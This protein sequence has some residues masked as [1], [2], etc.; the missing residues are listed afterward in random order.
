[1]SMSN[2]EYIQIDSDYPDTCYV[3]KDKEK[4]MTLFSKLFRPFC[5]TIIGN[6]QFYNR[7]TQDLRSQSYFLKMSRQHHMFNLI[8]SLTNKVQ[9]VYDFS[10]VDV[11]R[12][13][14]LIVYRDEYFLSVEHF[15][16]LKEQLVRGEMS[17]K[18]LFGQEKLLNQRRTCWKQYM[19]DIRNHLIYYWKNL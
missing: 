18:W 11:A 2:F 17:F 12:K 1:M 13:D 16:K 8:R 6:F 4:R 3:E 7:I 9:I 5:E 19:K 15:L 10:Q 14:S